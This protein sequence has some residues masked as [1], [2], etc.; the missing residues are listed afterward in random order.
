[1]GGNSEHPLP[2]SSAAVA[3][4]LALAIHEHRL[5]PGTKL[6]EDEVG[7]IFGVSRTLVRAA[8]QRLAH[9]RL[10]TLRRNR[11]AFV[12]QPS[13]REAR[14]VFEARALLEPRTARSAAE[15][16]TPEDVAR[17]QR[18]IDEEHAA[19]DAGDP[20]RALRLSGLFHVEIARIAD[21][22]TIREFITQLVARSSLIIALYWQR[23]AALCESHAHHAL[24]GALADRDGAAAEEMMKGHL[25]DLVSSLDLRNP[26]PPA[27]SLKEALARA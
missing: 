1:M 4:R 23:R 18:H 13:M 15:R 25:L 3:D 11:G 19:L 21:Q 9:D 14:E 10:V 2:E 12:A 6:S 7:E 8:L 17:L 24:L 22:D 26:A 5:Q 16:M 27:R 20:G